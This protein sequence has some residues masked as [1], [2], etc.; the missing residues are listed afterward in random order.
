MAQEIV[1]KDSLSR[2]MIVAG[3]EL[4]RELDKLHLDID[5]ALWL[6][7]PE[8][9]SWRF[10]VA[11]PEVKT[12]GPKKVYKQVQ[13]V[14]SKVVGSGDDFSLK[15]VTVHDSKDSFIQLLR[16]GL[17]T[18]DDISIRLSRGVIKGVP[19]GDA[20]IYRLT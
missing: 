17:R 11:T 5:A 13:S 6:Y 4:M 3:E 18:I 1:V 7:D 9:N 10:I 8:N 20:Y 2:E 19:I 14:I 15:D 12:K 16:S